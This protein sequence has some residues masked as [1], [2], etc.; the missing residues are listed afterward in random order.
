MSQGTRVAQMAM[1]TVYEAPLQMLADSP[2]IYQ[3]NQECCDFISKIPTIFDETKILSGKVG[4][5]I[6]TMRRKGQ[7][8]FIGAMTNWNSRNLTIDFSFLP[9]GEYK[10]DL[11][12]DG[13]N[14]DKEATDYKHISRPLKNDE[15][16]NIELSP[17]GGWTAQ[18]FPLKNNEDNLKY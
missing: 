8:W 13:I 16:L 4:E 12:Q 2:T 5:Y 1:Y 6:V 17:G 15:K 9:E 7:T 3:K 10:I 11:F 14:A 18:I